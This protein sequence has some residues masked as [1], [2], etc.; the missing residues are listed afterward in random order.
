[1]RL[2]N[3][4]EKLTHEILER[5]CEEYGAQVFAKVQLKDVLPVARSEISPSDFTFCL[6]S[7]FDFVVADPDSEALFGVEFDGP[8]HNKPE[9]KSRDCRKDELCQRCNFP[10]LR[11]NSGYLTKKHRE[12]DL[13]SYFVN[14][15]FLGDA[16]YK[17]QQEGIVPLDECFDPAMFLRLRPNGKTFPLWL[18]AESRAAVH[19]L[20]DAGK[21]HDSC[22]RHLVGHDSTKATRVLSYMQVT[23]TGGLLS[24]AAMRAQKFPA[25]EADV[26]M[27]IA[28]NDVY[29][30][31]LEVLDGSRSPMPLDE[32]NGRIQNFGRKYCRGYVGYRGDEDKKE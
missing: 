3:T 30:Q 12:Y 19:K 15:W 8:M 7:H 16:F 27:D 28:A 24:Q 13:L 4:Y 11:I 17:A 31:L 6:Q 2:L 1:M 23:P 18:S 29:A 20:W 5:A 21:C 14:V 22:I 9:R 10:L 26:L 32:L 25:V